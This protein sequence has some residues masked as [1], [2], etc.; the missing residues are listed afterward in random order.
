MCILLGLLFLIIY[1]KYQLL[2]VIFLQN[3]AYE[4][5]RFLRKVVVDKLIIDTVHTKKNLV[6]CHVDNSCLVKLLYLVCCVD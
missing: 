5:P 1:E 3:I 2:N 6:S 4:V